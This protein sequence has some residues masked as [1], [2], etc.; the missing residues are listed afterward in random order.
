MHRNQLF[1]EGKVWL[2][3]CLMV[4]VM[5]FGNKALAHEGHG[6]SL[7]ELAMHID[8]PLEELELPQADPSGSDEIIHQKLIETIVHLEENK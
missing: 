4:G 1:K 2:I 5:T 7:H 8:S 6:H 3:T